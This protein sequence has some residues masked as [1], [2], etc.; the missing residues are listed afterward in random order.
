MLLCLG[1]RKDLKLKLF[2]IKTQKKPQF[3]KNE[4]CFK[5]SY[6]LINKIKTNDKNNPNWNGQAFEPIF[7]I[8]YNNSQ[9][10]LRPKIAEINIPNRILN[11]IYET[12]KITMKYLISQ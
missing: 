7:S 11:E 5:Y 4:K 8:C 2:I 6:D 10:G 12:S 9:T 1:V 3:F